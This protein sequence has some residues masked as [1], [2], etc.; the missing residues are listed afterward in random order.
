MRLASNIVALA[1]LS[2]LLSTGC[3]RESESAISITLV[4]ELQEGGPENLEIIRGKV[5]RAKPGQRIVLYAHSLGLWY[6][7]PASARPFTEIK[8]DL[9][10]QSVIHMG[11][12]YAA[13]LVD[14]T[15]TPTTK[16]RDLPAEG[17]PVVAIANVAGST[18]HPKTVRFSG[19]NWEVRREY[20]NRDGKLNPYDPENA[21]VD[22]DGF[23]HLQL[24]NPDKQWFCA[25]V[26]L[27]QSLGHGLYRFTVRD[28]S[29]M[30]P[31]AVLT[32]Y[33]WGSGERFNREV[34]VEVSRFGDPDAAHNGQF[35]V[36]P[37]YEPSNN[38]HFNIPPGPATFSFQW[39]PGVLLFS[40]IHG[41]DAR[42][43]ASHR[44]DSGVP[45]PGGESVRINLYPFGK[46]RVPMKERTEV[47]I[48]SFTYSP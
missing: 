47:I 12:R 25:G 46:A 44:F 35:V 10:W 40:S 32:M 18:P 2:S 33:T 20:S 41:S 1:L 34:D 7:Q 15:F 9:T 37:Y 36:Q 8:P 11:D 39:R 22:K 42:P 17:G 14:S 26:R 24:V 43:S 5:L 29:Q 48:E 4:P 31:A 38:S 30:D 13:L 16:I 6:S 28:T 3:R 27:T 45:E 23:L 21:W 19:Y